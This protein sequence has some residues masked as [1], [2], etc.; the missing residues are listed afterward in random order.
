MTRQKSLSK[1]TCSPSASRAA[2]PGRCVAGAAPATR[3]HPAPRRAS[4][5]SPDDLD[6]V[7][8]LAAAVG[9][10]GRVGA[11]GAPRSQ[12]GWSVVS[13]PSAVLSSLSLVQAAPNNAS[14]TNGTSARL[15]VI[16][17]MS[18]LWCRKAPC[19][20]RTAPCRQPVTDGTPSTPF[21][22]R[23]VVAGVGPRRAHWAAMTDASASDPV[24]VRFHRTVRPGECRSGRIRR[25]D[26]GDGAA[27]ARDEPVGAECQRL[28]GQGRSDPDGAER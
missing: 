5:R 9:S 1:P 21:G 12:S 16:R 8:G 26:E 15:V 18:P 3:R 11:I 14:A 22:G 13:V 4:S 17:I 23:S 24:R 25:G 27:P 19:V 20:L 7:V 10:L 2:K 28:R 6:G